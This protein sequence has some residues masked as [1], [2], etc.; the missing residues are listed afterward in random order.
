M[1]QLGNGLSAAGHHEEALSVGE[2]ELAMAQ[3]IGASEEAILGVQSNL[4]IMYQMLGR[5]EEALSLRRE[6]YSGLLRLNGEEHGKTILAANNYAG[7]LFVLERFE[8]AKEY[9]R[10][11]VSLARSALGE[12][13]EITIR[14]R[15]TYARALYS[16]ADATLA[17]LREAATTLE[18]TERTAQQVLGGAHPTT[19][20]IKISLRKAR[21]KLRAREDAEP[22]SAQELDA[23]EAAAAAA[24]AAAAIKRRQRQ[25]T[26]ERERLR[27]TT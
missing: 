26:I 24:V 2:A 20:G 8:E 22:V 16:N 25:D 4:A 3:R 1:T 13:N 18:E 7:S 5:H 17:D 9:L 11:K 15:W 21:A 23:A 6:V 27:T 10:E 14:M 12:N 19:K